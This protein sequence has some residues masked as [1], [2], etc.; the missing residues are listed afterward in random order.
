[1]K[2]TAK[3]LIFLIASSI[4][5]QANARL[6]LQ[7][8]HIFAPSSQQI[9]SFAFQQL[10]AI[11][12]ELT[13]LKLSPR[14]QKK[15]RKFLNENQVSDFLTRKE[16]AYKVDELSLLLF[17]KEISVERRIS[18]PQEIQE[19]RRFQQIFVEAILQ[20]GF[21]R[22]WKVPSD[23]KMIDLMK[24]KWNLLS[25]SK[26]YQYVLLPWFLPRTKGPKISQELLH[27]IMKE[28]LP[29]HLAEVQQVLKAKSQH[30]AYVL[31]R[32]LYTPVIL[33][34]LFLVQSYLA[35]EALQAAQEEQVQKA[36]AE[37]YQTGHLIE[38]MLETTKAEILETAYQATLTEFKQRWGEEPTELE[39]TEIREK[40]ILHLKKLNSPA[41]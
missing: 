33:G 3:G 20:R 18:Q 32:R 35:H 9:Y 17:E 27:K 30:E 7:C 24:S 39:K 13:T 21:Q 34:S 37:M 15:V 11:S 23:Y 28:G 41:E 22:Q 31:F 29:Q 19:K 16:L 2:I 40:I 10:M 38:G 5:L 36:V 25:E 6:L 4:C 12:P 8:R 1:M 26:G 14:Q